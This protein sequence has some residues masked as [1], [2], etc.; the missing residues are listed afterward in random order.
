MEIGDKNLCNGCM[1]CVY[2]CPQNC[3]EII[4]NEEGFLYPHIEEDKCIHCGICTRTCEGCK[5]YFVEEKPIKSFASYNLDLL[6][7]KNSSSGGIFSVLAEWI[8]NHGGY[9]V[10]AAYVSKDK[11]EHIIVGN[12]NELP[13]LMGSKYVQSFIGN[14]LGEVKKL[15]EKQKKVLFSGTPCQLAGLKAYLGK[16]YENLYLVDLVCHGTPSPKLFRHYV[17]LM[18]EKHKKEI[19]C[20]NFRDKSHSWQKYHV[21][22]KFA[23][24]SFVSD[25]HYLNAYMKGFSQNVSL[26]NSCYE[27]ACKSLGRKSDITLA[28]FWGVERVVPEL[29]TDNGVSWITVHS[30][31]GM[32][33]LEQVKDK[34]FLLEVND[35]EAVKNNLSAIKSVTKGKN[36][37]IYYEKVLTTK[38]MKSFEKQVNKMIGYNLFSRAMKKVKRSLSK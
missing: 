31:K 28:D 29:Q 34:L 36:R 8:I 30:Q 16:E 4:E 5:D 17:K 24:G 14:V 25:V 21:V 7:R 3:I 12:K 11:V 20:V 38:N 6:Q 26:R 15:L 9:V 27:N 2:K 37:K 23:D 18:E 13:E 19:R 32:D 1:A 22:V 33:I 10:G 35:T